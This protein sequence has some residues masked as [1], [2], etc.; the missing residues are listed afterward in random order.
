MDSRLTGFALTLL[1]P[2]LLAGI[3]GV[4]LAWYCMD[5][6]G[7]N[8][9]RPLPPLDTAQADLQQRLSRHVYTLAEDIGERHHEALPALNRAADYIEQQFRSFG[10]VPAVREFGEQRF[11]NISVELHGREQGDQVIVV[12]AHYDTVWL[13]PGADD[14]ASGVAGLLEIARALHGRR[15]ARTL[16]LIAFVNEEEPFYGTELMGSRRSAEASR[17]RGE[18]IVAMYSLEMI[19]Y[20]SDQPGSQHYPRMIRRFYPQQADFIAFVS[21]LANARLL[22][23][24][25]RRFRQQAVFPAEG[26]AAPEWLVP[27]V[28]RSDHAAYWNVRYP[29]LMITD[30]ANYRNYA[31]HNT[32]D[33]ARTLDYAA[34]ARVVSGLTGMLAAMADD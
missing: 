29:A 9:R 30:T 11:R 34:M 15:F 28:N 8:P 31:Y 21:N 4:V 3:A 22:R 24:S 25:V 5:M 27:D 17:N 7:T 19:G 32:G 12:G 26:L 2:L 6:P 18:N 16:R 1:L 33:V 13:S 14:N 10:Y 20:Y 23:D